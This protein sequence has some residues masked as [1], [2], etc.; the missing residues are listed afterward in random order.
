MRQLCSDSDVDPV[1]CRPRFS[2]SQP[3]S[4]TGEMID[5]LALDVASEDGDAQ[6]NSVTWVQSNREAANA[7]IGAQ[8][9][10]TAALVPVYVLDIHGR[11]VVIIAF[12]MVKLRP[13]TH[14]WI[15]INQQTGGAT[16][17][18]AQEAAETASL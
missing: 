16:D 9:G 1:L 10:N 6:P 7:D 12:Q 13:T 17:L 5:K 11:S 2:S 4:A 18:A 3:H 8:V 15:V 14:T